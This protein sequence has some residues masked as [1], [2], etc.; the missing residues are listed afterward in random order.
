MPNR[1]STV[2]GIEGN[3]DDREAFDQALGRAGFTAIVVADARDGL[4]IVADH[5]PDLVVVEPRTTGCDGIHILSRIR[6]AAA[7]D[8]LPVMFLTADT[9]ETDR[10]LGLEMGADDYIGKPFSPRELV[11]RIRTVLR[12]TRRS[13]AARGATPRLVHRALTLDPERRLF[14][15]ADRVIGLTAMEFRLMELLMAD[16]GK[17]FSRGELSATIRDTAPD[18]FDRAIDAHVKSIRRKL[19]DGAVALQTVRGFGYKI[20]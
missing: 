16:V 4:A 19:G 15:N 8:C 14:Q 2:L 18:P 17:V 7:N 13:A 9:S 6:S 10:V 12:R 11:A 3:R 1:T 5:R 20:A